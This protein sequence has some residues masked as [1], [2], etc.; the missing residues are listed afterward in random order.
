MTEPNHHVTAVM[1]RRR[2]DALLML[3]EE[4]LAG[5]KAMAATLAKHISDEDAVFQKIAVDAFPAGDSVGHR[6][7]HEA[8]IKRVEARAQFWVTLKTDI[9]KWGLIGVIG[10]L[11]TWGWIGFLKGPKL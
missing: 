9:A 5:Q 2:D 7:I 1:D 3:V 10:F 11:L 8:D 4:V 6:R